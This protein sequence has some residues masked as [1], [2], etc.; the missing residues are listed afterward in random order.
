MNLHRM[1]ATTLGAAIGLLALSSPAEALIASVKT[2]GMAATGV[3]YPQDAQAAVFNPAGAVE[4]CDRF[5]S[6]FEWVRENG[7]S[8]IR[9]NIIDNIPPLSNA[10]GGKINGKFEGFK[11][12]DFY[13]ADFGVNMRLGSCDEF[14]V[15]LVVY[16][17]NFVK[18]TFNK[19][20]VLFGTSNPGLEY[21]NQTISPVFAYK[22]NECHNVGLTINCQVQ[23]LKVNGL[24]KFNTPTRTA[25]PGHLTNRGYDWSVGWGVTLGWQWH[26]TDCFTFGA[27]FQPKT[28]MPKF[29]KY[30]GF[31]VKGRIEVP[32][33]WSVGLAWRYS[34]NGTIAFDIQQY[35]WD[36]VRALHNNLLFEGER[37][38]L[39]TQHGPGFGFK[40]QTFYRLGIDYD[41]S[42][43]W[44]VRAGF[45]YGKAP[46]GPSQTAVNQLTLDC[47][48]YYA[49][50]GASYRPSDKVELS[51]LVAWG[52]ENTI[53][54]KNSIPAGIP[55]NIPGF[56]FNPQGFGGGEADLTES[57]FILGFSLGYYY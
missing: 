57:K 14:A 48:E 22:I 24:E 54:G 47:V 17:R 34:C 56:P 50:L 51:T 44:T 32:Q 45:R 11:T 35:N 33:M 26:I 55:V 39:G 16:N 46:F 30:K 43:E 18:T 28:D 3:A 15:G 8:R 12:K 42:C 5:D 20:F 41:L 6:G 53:K 40:T 13:N 9:G 29:K 21:L 49:T 2:F 52:F 27:T 23:R 19:P 38:L 31:A 25:F 36:D 4:I 1:L 10:L 37:E 7:Y